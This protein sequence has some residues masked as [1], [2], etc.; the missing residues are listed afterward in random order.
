M[1]VE[2][3]VALTRLLAEVSGHQK[4]LALRLT[5]DEYKAVLEHTLKTDL[6]GDRASIVDV[7]EIRMNGVKL[8]PE[9]VIV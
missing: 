7:T 4:R 2:E 5:R 9:R 8:I 1:N 6:V 3:I